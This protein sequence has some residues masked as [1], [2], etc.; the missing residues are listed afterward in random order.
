METR[1]HTV[2][3]G[4]GLALSITERVQ[5]QIQTILGDRAPAEVVSRAAELTRSACG[6]LAILSEK[7]G[8]VRWTWGEGY[9]ESLALRVAGIIAA[10]L[11]KDSEL[12]FYQIWPD[13]RKELCDQ[14]ERLKPGPWSP[15]QTG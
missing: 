13:V 11:A 12:R 10:A 4:R 2:P 9:P 6:I 3:I 5:R 15:G 8:G 14:N 7:A 1:A